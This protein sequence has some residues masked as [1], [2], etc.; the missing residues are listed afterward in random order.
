M[1]EN[2]E[3][4]EDEQEDEALDDDIKDKSEWPAHLDVDVKEA[5]LRFRRIKELALEK[6]AADKNYRNYRL[7]GHN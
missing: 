5:N 7:L 6:I 2:I 4:I 1:D 3:Y